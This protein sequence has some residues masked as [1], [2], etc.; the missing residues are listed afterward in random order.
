MNRNDYPLNHS[1]N[2]TGQTLSASTPPGVTA[3]SDKLAPAQS[4]PVQAKESAA[5]SASTS[6]TAQT[7]A[8]YRPKRPIS[9]AFMQA[10]P[11]WLAVGA[12]VL[13]ALMLRPAASSIGAELSEIQT[14]LKLSSTVAGL[15]T[16]LPGFVFTV[17]GILANRIVPK[18]GLLGTL[19]FA[20]GITLLGVSLRVL[21]G[22]VWLFLVLSILA[23]A[24]MAIGN[25]VLPAFVKI[26]FPKSSAAISTV[27]T[28]FLAI[29]AALPPLFT[30]LLSNWGENW[31]GDGH[32]W[33]L[34]LEFWA[35]IP[36]LAL[37]V[38]LPLLK[39][40]PKL[41]RT[42][43]FQ[44]QQSVPMRALLKSPTALALLFFFGIQSMHGYIL[45]GWLPTMY[46]DGGV[47]AS[48][49]NFATAIYMLGGMPGGLVMPRILEKSTRIP[50]WIISFGLAMIAGYAGMYFCPQVWPLLWA[51][52]LAYSG[53]CFPTALALIIMRTRDPAVTATVSG[54]VQPI[55]YL[56]AGFG[57]LAVGAAIE[58][59]GN[60][61]LI[62]T[63]ACVSAVALSIC[64][65]IASRNR[66]IDDE[67]DQ[68]F[69]AT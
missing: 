55:G 64:G 54:F 2:E 20:C 50:Y 61:L 7:T 26:A 44:S 15:L 14:S 40:N 49:A 5:S 57:P 29:G 41:N 11:I 38:W 42:P 66:M 19:A 16:A 67:I 10:K 39:L 1:T 33:R 23:L 3:R 48:F 35:I 47:D 51:L 28:V 31:L 18:A 46:Q 45:G 68:K 65:L 58:A 43:V 30:S 25:V 21:T 59:L 36:L 32:G 22:Q 69:L 62:D 24:G 56:L 52:L 53:F 34:S 8:A 12:V 13:T 4:Q 60:W 27:Y 17:F 63:L 9:S 37:A 6:S